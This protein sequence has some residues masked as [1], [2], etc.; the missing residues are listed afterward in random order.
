MSKKTILKTCLFTALFFLAMLCPAAG[1]TIIYVN[2][3]ATPPG[4]GLG[5]PTAYTCLQ[6]ALCD[7]S[8]PGAQIWVAAGTYKPDEGLV[9]FTGTV[10]D[11]NAKFVLEPSVALYGAFAGWETD[12][13]QRNWET[14]ETIL[15][16]DIGTP[17][18]NTDNSYQVVY[19]GHD[20][21]GATILDGFTIIAG[22]AN[23]PAPNNSGGGMWNDQG[24]PTVENCIFIANSATLSGGAMLNYENNPTL[25]NCT[26]ISNS[27]KFGGAMYNDSNS[28]PVLA[29]C[30]FIAN[31]ADSNGGAMLNYNSNPTLT[32]CTFTANHAVVNGGG[33]A[34]V[35]DVSG[36][37]IPIPYPIPILT[38]CT[39]GENTAGD[40]GGA[41]YNESTSPVLNSCTFTAN[42]AVVNG[43]G[44]ATV[45]NNP[46]P[47][48]FPFPEPSLTICTFGENTAGDSGGG[49]Y[50]ENTS[51]ILTDCTFTANQAL[52]I[53]I[54]TNCTFGEN[55]ADGSGG[56]MYNESTSPVLNSCTFTANEAVVNGGGIATI[57]DVSDIPT[58]IPYPEPILTN[59]TFGENTA[60]DSGG[61][62]YN[63]DAGPILNTCRF[64]ENQAVV[65]G[66]GIATVSTLPVPLPYPKLTNCTF[67]SNTS[68]GSGAGVYNESTS[69]E[70]KSCTFSGNSATGDGG[71]IVTVSTNP[72]PL[73]YPKP[74][75]TNCTFSANNALGN[76]GGIACVS[77]DPIP[78]PDP[79]LTNCILWGNSDSGGINES[80]QIYGGTTVSYS[81]IQGLDRFVGNGNIDDEPY[82]VDPNGTN[83]I[84]GDSDDDLRLWA[85]S[86]C[87][88]AG[89][90][91]LEYVDTDGSRN[92]IGAYGGP[93]GN[94]G[95]P[96]SGLEAGFSFTGVGNIPTS[97]IG[98]NPGE[99]NFGLA[100]L[101]SNTADQLGIYTYRHS[102]F[103]GT[104]WLNGLFGPDDNVDYYQILV[105]MW[106][107]ENPPILYAPL[108][109][110][111][112]KVHYFVDP[113]SADTYDTYEHVNL[114]PRTIPG[115]DGNDIDNLYKLTDEGFWSHIDLRARWNTKTY[116][117]AK[118]TLTYKAYRWDPC[119]P[120]RLVDANDLPS[121][122]LDSLVLVVDNNTVTAEIHNLKYDNG[123]IIPECAFI[124]LNDPFENVRF[125]I[126]AWHPNG[127]LSGYT[128]KVIS[129]KNMDRGVIDSDS[130]SYSP[131]TEVYWHGVDE[132]EVNSADAMAAGKMQEWINCAYQ[133]HLY[134]SA[135]TTNGFHYIYEASF[136]DDYYVDS[137]TAYCGRADINLDGKVDFKDLARLGKEWLAQ[138]CG[139]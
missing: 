93:F 58:P 82:F 94:I 51:P 113:C 98:Q 90:I 86:P 16:G 61:A 15:S 139:L 6:D 3:S 66:G 34:T 55:T 108:S 44:I 127:Y 8:A 14:N 38:N 114:G 126:T 128:L 124:G 118:Y 30:H 125:N 40:S 79:K 68:G 41:M 104:I 47:M 24:S 1:Q 130:Y 110:P 13:S 18:D 91:G 89:A 76:G 28:S 133:F 84:P 57:S 85:D 39:F 109:D 72:V 19:T 27:S 53:P 123:Q 135:R 2:A 87:I 26:F 25:T 111:L 74:I 92:D 29:D 138:P 60:A 101:D 103:G 23:G 71:G 99:P 7:L 43:G 33:I 81:C 20:V 45:S 70:L 48:P 9:C 136:I 4:N 67:G 35:S 96:G 122:P 31:T 80:A 75:L 134:A 37:P 22:N 117:N 65:N 83:N 12:L 52:P 56:A 106:D 21:D 100:D 137:G 42:E 105:G 10:G 54:L 73:P 131:A 95:T 120:D 64:S 88:D 132:T 59:C 107:G 32:D 119:Q 78:L 36:L 115:T 69:P 129:P 102:P 97:Q 63:E 77:T 121:N 49:M 50:N 46:I 62:M 116:E 5:W 11:P 112:T 17:G